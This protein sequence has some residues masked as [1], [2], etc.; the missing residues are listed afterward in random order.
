[1]DE[2]PLAV[3][4][5]LGMLHLSPCEALLKKELLALHNSGVASKPGGH[6]VGTKGGRKMLQT[7]SVPLITATRK[8]DL[9]EVLRLLSLGAD[10]DG[11]S[12]DGKLTPLIAAALK[13]H[14]EVALVLL[15]AGASPSLR[16]TRGISPLD[17]A[18][19][20]GSLDTLHVLLR[21]GA[22]PMSMDANGLTPFHHAIIYGH[23]SVVQG[24]VHSGVDIESRTGAPSLTPPL[25]IA[26]R[27]GHLSIV[28]FFL[29]KGADVNAAEEQFGRTAMH[30][31]A[32]RNAGI[33]ILVLEQAGGDVNHRDSAGFT[34][35]FT[36][37]FYG[38]K[39]AIEV[40]L[41]QGAEKHMKDN[42]DQ[43]P[44]Q[45]V[46]KCTHLADLANDC[47]VEECAKTSAIIEL[48]KS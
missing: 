27:F 16:S 13:D 22:D 44:D 31:A 33:I 14:A 41:E 1:M 46:C 11:F 45:V 19:V 15:E 47:R 12:S 17:I 39:L 10:V 21:A 32:A 37:A 42:N 20:E 9:S 8:G 24:L 30:H 26:A 48:V 3:I 18:A 7:H 28:R 6:V 36:A 2:K 34:P 23:L 25:Q 35:L 40:L 5:L 38:N 43:S 4:L 29:E